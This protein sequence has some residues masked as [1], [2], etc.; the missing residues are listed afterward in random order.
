VGEGIPVA[1]AVK[2]PAAPTVNVVLGP[3]VMAGA[4]LTVNV[5]FC[6]ASGVTP[7]LAVM[8]M[9]YVPPVFAAG[10][11]LSTPAEK[12]RPAGNVPVALKAGVGNPVA[13]GVND[14]AT[15]GLNEAVGP[16]VMAGAWLTVN[17]KL[18]VAFGVTPLEAVMVMGYV[19]PVLAAGVP[20]STPAE[21]VTP[22]G[23]V[24][25]SLKV[26]VG[27]PVA[28]TVNDAAAPTLNV[29]LAGLVMAGAR[30]PVPC[31]VTLWLAAVAF[32]ALSVNVATPLIAPV[33]CGVKLRLRL[34]LAP[35]A[36]ERPLVQSAGV[37]EPAV[38]GKFGSTLRPGATALSGWLP[39]F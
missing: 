33:L 34:Q 8:M 32:R 16:L 19:P 9:G 29:V 37:P 21:K 7:L 4:W 2:D 3:L 10:V 6:V 15:P 23:S 28:V 39:M 18:C 11:P 30:W 17:V 13:V 1:V 27:I 12:V 26:G 25:V 14:A 35:G 24:P 5:K 38:C 22:A 31:M 36:S 20:L